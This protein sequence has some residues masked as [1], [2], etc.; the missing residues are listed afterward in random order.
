[1]C[2]SDPPDSLSK[3]T[4]QKLIL[5]LSSEL[6]WRCEGTALPGNFSALVRKE[7]RL[8]LEEYIS[9]L[10]CGG[11]SADTCVQN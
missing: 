3:K 4:F 1:M 10:R 9:Y 7:G 11:G 2:A 8:R 6:P 5:D